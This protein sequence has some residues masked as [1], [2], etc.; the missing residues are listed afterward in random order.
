MVVLGTLGVLCGGM[1]C[2]MGGGMEARMHCIFMNILSQTLKGF[3][4]R[5]KKRT[6]SKKRKTKRRK[7]KRKSKSRR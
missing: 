4:K 7:R 5:K 1:G 2:G 6:K 3:G